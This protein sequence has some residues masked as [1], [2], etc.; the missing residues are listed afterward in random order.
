MDNEY[1]FKLLKAQPILRELY[2]QNK[3]DK[4]KLLNLKQKLYKRKIDF[5]KKQ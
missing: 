3:L 4:K 5:E 2:L 1:Y